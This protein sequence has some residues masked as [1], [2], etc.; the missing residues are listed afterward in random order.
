MSSCVQVFI[1]LALFC[2][3]ISAL[4]VGGTRRN[5]APNRRDVLQRVAGSIAG[6]V[7]TD[8][9]SPLQAQAV[10]KSPVKA[11]FKAYRIIPDASSA[12]NPKIKSIQ[13]CEKTKICII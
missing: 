1:W 11:D 5:A 6:G 7:L 3:G 8:F 12:L 13:V 2:H 4:D 9:V 10:E